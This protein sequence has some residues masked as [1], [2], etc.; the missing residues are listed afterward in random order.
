MGNVNRK[1][2]NAARDGQLEVLKQ[3]Y[4]RNG[5]S[6]NPHYNDD[7]AFHLACRNGHA[8]VARW[9]YSLGPVNTRIIT[10]RILAS[11]CRNG[12]LEIAQWL[13]SLDGV[14]ID[15]CCRT[16]MQYCCERGHLNVAKWL[17]SLSNAN[18]AIQRENTFVLSCKYGHL[19]VTQWIHS[20]RAHHSNDYACHAFMIAGTYGH[21]DIA[22]WLCSLYRIDASNFDFCLRNV[23]EDNSCML[24]FLLENGANIERACRTPEQK[25]ELLMRLR[26]WKNKVEVHEILLQ[27]VSKE[28]WCY[29]DRDA[30]Q[31]ILNKTKSAQK[32]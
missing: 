31:S 29:L 4:A 21:V 19:P 7:D 2:I 28:D 22:E 14:E 20:L 18:T 27:Y 17:H 3:I 13:Y 6:I 32:N 9:I 1:F 24:Q 25:A 16:S 30:I 26:L 8:D 15:T 10:N 11:A 12:H 5:V 23:E